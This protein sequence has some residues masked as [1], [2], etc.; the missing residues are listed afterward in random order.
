M[1]VP[2]SIPASVAA[3]DMR[4]LGNAEPLEPYPGRAREPWMCRHIP[5]KQVIYPNPNNVM[6]GQGACI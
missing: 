4:R 5:C 1:A 6:S 2:P 3:A